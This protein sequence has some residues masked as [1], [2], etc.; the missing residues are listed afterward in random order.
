M[1]SVYDT[2]GRWRKKNLEF[3]KHLKMS[4]DKKN[5]LAPRT[6]MRDQNNTFS[7][8]TMNLEQSNPIQSFLEAEN[9]PLLYSSRLPGVGI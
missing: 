5:S 8:T 6:S 1:V 2:S 7:R 4:S 9:A 3:M